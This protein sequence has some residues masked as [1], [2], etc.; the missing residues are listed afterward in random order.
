MKKTSLDITGQKSTILLVY[1]IIHFYVFALLTFILFHDFLSDIIVFIV[2]KL[3][4]AGIYSASEYI[5][6]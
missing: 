2:E 4:P 3:C 6:Y 5:F 1:Y